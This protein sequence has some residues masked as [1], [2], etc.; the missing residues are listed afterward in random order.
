MKTL[1]ELREERNQKAARMTEL[2][3]IS[4]MDENEASE[5]DTL[6]AECKQLDT[7]I[8]KARLDFLNS[9]AATAVE[10]KSTQQGSRSRS[11]NII[12]KS[13]DVDEKLKARTI[14][15]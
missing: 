3:E 15:A 10:G 1:Q 13:S 7:E 5:F 6:E 8:R 9:G 11:P 4:D 2:L 12:I 14:P